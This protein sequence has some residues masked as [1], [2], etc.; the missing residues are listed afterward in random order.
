[1]IRSNITISGPRYAM[2][3][4]KVIVSSVIRRF[5]ITKTDFENVE[6][7]KIKADIVIKSVY[8]YNAVLELRNK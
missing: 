8:G 6:D 4:I 2:M 3:A 1:M 7:I 5:K